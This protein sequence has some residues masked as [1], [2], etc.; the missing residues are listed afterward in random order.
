MIKIEKE[1]MYRPAYIEPNNKTWTLSYKN[2]LS[3][4]K[5]KLCS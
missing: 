2:L 5:Y 1:A 3:T 4:W